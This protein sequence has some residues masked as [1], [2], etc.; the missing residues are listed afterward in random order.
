MLHNEYT[1]ASLEVLYRIVCLTH[2]PRVCVC[3]YTSKRTTWKTGGT[4]SLLWLECWDDVERL[5]ENVWFYCCNLFF[6]VKIVLCLWNVRTYIPHAGQF[7][8]CWGS[9]SSRS[10]L[11]KLLSSLVSILCIE[12]Y[13]METRYS[14]GCSYFSRVDKMSKS[15]ILCS[16]SSSHHIKTPVVC[17]PAEENCACMY[18][19][20]IVVQCCR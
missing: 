20:I 2:C 17:F 14:I 19:S 12:H 10:I 4:A 9:M 11:I 6:P 8:A 16:S 15:I 7:F 13:G 3:T 1:C 18:V 5:S